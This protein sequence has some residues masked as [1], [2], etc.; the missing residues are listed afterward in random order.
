[1]RI[2][3]VSH[4]FPPTFGGVETHLWDLSRALGR[5]GHTVRCLVGGPTA[6]EDHGCVS[7]IRRPE[8]TVQSLLRQRRGFD[9]AQCN[10]LLRDRLATVVAAA[11]G[12]W[13]PQVVH[14]H[15]AHHFAPE[16][17]Q[18][19][20]SDGHRPATLNGVHDRVGEH[21]Y[22]EVLGYAWDQVV[23]ASRYLRDSLPCGTV[24]FT[25][26]WLGI[27]LASFTAT[28]PLDQR[29]VALESPV[30]FHP[31]RLLRW[32][33]PDVGLTAFRLLRERLGRGSLVLCASRNV[34]DDPVEVRTLRHEL[35]EA[36]TAGGIGDHVRFLEFERRSMASAYRASD[37]VWY[38]TVDDEPFGLV[39]LEAMAWGVPHVV[40]DSGGM[41][42][43]VVSEE[44]GLVV[45]KNDP[46]ALAAAAVRL[47]S[48]GA[49]RERLVAAGRERVRAFDM[50]TY[51]VQIERLYESVAR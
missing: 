17:A 32:K 5:R 43:T 37:L 51:V 11:V 46:A 39:P 33:G 3:L 14:L 20:L 29:L 47:L 19:F 41:R 9:A 45:P 21:L 6:E 1:M 42:E 27:D 23:F 24:P 10:A 49:L 35:E 48:D 28:G 4:A 30:I 25:V 40:S 16:L 13:L 50:R 22:P 7:V 34:V 12:D 8:L 26:L 31:A 15:N 44:T 2:L 36:A 38:P 18:V